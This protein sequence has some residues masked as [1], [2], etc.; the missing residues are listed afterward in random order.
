MGDY[1]VVADRGALSA[2]ALGSCVAVLL[3]D[4][5][6]R[7]GGLAHVMLPSLALS[8]VRDRPARSAETAVP[9]LLDCVRD[10]GALPAHVRAWL[11][12]GATMFADLLP[13]GAMHIGERNV[14]ACRFALRQAGVPVVGSAVGGV[15][16]RTVWLDVGEGTVTVRETGGTPFTL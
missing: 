6:G 12:G 15:R 5:Q 4:R 7:V 2:L 9:W 16:G 14:Q 10:A 1:A 3:Y 11:V 8:R 13:S